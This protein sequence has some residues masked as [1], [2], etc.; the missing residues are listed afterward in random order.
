MI[1]N[2]NLNFGYFMQIR[3]T[4]LFLTIIRMVALKSGDLGMEKNLVI[5]E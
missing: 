2:L 1:Q 3:V 4:S 5:D